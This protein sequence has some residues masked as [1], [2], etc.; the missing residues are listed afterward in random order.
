V[1]EI[2][3]FGGEG[4]LTAGYIKQPLGYWWEFFKQWIMFAYAAKKPF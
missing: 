4:I 1:G 2:E 3:W